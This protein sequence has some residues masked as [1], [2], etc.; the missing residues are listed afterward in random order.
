MKRYPGMMVA[1][2][3]ALAGTMILASL[4]RAENSGDQQW[5][6]VWDCGE[7]MLY[8]SGSVGRVVFDGIEIL[9]WYVVD[10]LSHRWNWG[11]ENENDFSVIATSTEAS[12]YDF[13]SVDEGETKLPSMTFNCHAGQ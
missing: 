11:G 1:A 5:E 9:A 12:Y 8:K 2:A 13:Q 10:G 7:M 6:R 4:A 3:V